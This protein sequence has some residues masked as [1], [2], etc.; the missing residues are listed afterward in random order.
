[1][2]EEIAGI[3]EISSTFLCL[4]SV[5]AIVIGLMVV[6]GNYLYH[7]RQLSAEE[8][9]R[10]FKPR[11]AWVLMVALEI[12]VVAD[13]IETVTTEITFES[14]ATLGLLVIVRTWLSWTLALEAEGRWPWQPAAEE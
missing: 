2:P 8:S 10:K 3:F 6:F 11:L 4:F 5:L 12:L 13:I 9:F 1:M 14:L 7:F